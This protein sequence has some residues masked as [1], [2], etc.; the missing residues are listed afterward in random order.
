MPIHAYT[1]VLGPS[2]REYDPAGLEWG[3]AICTEEHHASWSHLSFLETAYT[4]GMT[5]KYHDS[6]FNKG[7][8][9]SQLTVFSE[10]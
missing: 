4:Q 3:S 9:V 1:H 2:S 5:A 10:I 7:R 6:L 8:K